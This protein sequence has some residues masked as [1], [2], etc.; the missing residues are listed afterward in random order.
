[1]VGKTCVHLVKRRLVPRKV[2]ICSRGSHQGAQCD[3]SLSAL[4]LFIPTIKSMCGHMTRSGLI[5]STELQ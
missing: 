2:N 1:M 3:L 5:E 4:E